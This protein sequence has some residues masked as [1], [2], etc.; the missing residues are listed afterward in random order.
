[1]ETKTIAP[2]SSEEG[3]GKSG[4]TTKIKKMSANAAK[5]TG[6]ATIGAAATSVMANGAVT[7]EVLEEGEMSE[8]ILSTPDV[9]DE[10]SSESH[11]YVNPNEV[12]IEIE[13][14]EEA[15]EEMVEDVEAVIEYVDEENVDDETAYVKPEPITEEGIDADGESESLIMEVSPSESQIAEADLEIIDEDDSE[16]LADESVDDTDDIDVVDDILNA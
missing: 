5:F 12:R 14:V 6:A 10:I 4:K 16:L 3:A 2:I 1:M 7:E 15:S 13:E 9:A 8:E 11:T